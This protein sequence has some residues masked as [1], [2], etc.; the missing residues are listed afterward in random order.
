MSCFK[1]DF[2]DFKMQAM[3]ILLIFIQTRNKTRTEKDVVIILYIITIISYLTITFLHYLNN[4]IMHIVK[5]VTCLAFTLFA[6]FL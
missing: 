6:G 5:E 1:S 4:R 3:Y 2:V